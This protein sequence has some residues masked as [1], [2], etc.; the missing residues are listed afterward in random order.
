MES[1]YNSMSKEVTEIKSFIL[2]APTLGPGHRVN[3]GSTAVTND[4]S[5]DELQLDH[6]L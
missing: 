6:C 4:I 2:S 1:D 3:A 5:G